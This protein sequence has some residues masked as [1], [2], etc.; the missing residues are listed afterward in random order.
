MHPT[1]STRRIDQGSYARSGRRGG[2]LL[3]VFLERPERHLASLTLAGEH[4]GIDLVDDMVKE[5]VVA[6]RLPLD[7]SPGCR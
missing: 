5:F 6:A 1:L 7:C 3:D 4:L 2:R